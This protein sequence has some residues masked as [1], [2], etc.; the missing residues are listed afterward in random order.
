[1]STYL[2]FK[3]VN[4]PLLFSDS[5]HSSAL[6]DALKKR[7]PKTYAAVLMPEGGHL[8]V[9]DDHA[10]VASFRLQVILRSLFPRVVWESPLPPIRKIGTA[11]TL[12]TLRAL[13]HTP[14]KAGRCSH[15]CEW[16]W[17]TSLD[18]IGAIEHPWMTPQS[19]ERGLGTHR[20]NFPDQLF[21]YLSAREHQAFVP[22]LDLNRN[23]S[24][25][26]SAVLAAVALAQRKTP[27]EVLEDP[28]ARA[29]FMSLVDPQ[30]QQRPLRSIPRTS[31]AA[32]LCLHT[33][34]LAA[35][36][37]HR[38]AYSALSRDTGKSGRALLSQASTIAG[39]A[40]SKSGWTMQ[41]VS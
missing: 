26:R 29:S 41:S 36:S 7:F 31:R 1:M 6:W 9:A 24:P 35:I 39:V 23:P 11:R 18:L 34:K 8:L 4:A 21:N 2:Q 33:P 27:F 25:S 32:I 15:P 20:A 38:A 13:L 16:Q 19:L 40:S 37:P 22:A 5:R 17:S 12:C 10:E 30:S 28:E 14:V 3:T